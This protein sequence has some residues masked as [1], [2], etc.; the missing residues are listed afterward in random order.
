[1]R[2]LA[3]LVAILLVIGLGVGYSRA[4]DQPA[5][6]PTYL[7]HCASPAAISSPDTLT[8][9]TTEASVGQDLELLETNATAAATPGQFQCA[10]PAAT[11]AG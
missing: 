9:P 11:A 4:Q 5:T 10:T 7:V 6:P 8:D 2:K 3:V 1:M